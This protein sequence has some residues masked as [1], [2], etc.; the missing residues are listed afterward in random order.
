MS[1]AVPPLLQYAFMAWCLVKYRDNFTFTF[2]FTISQTTILRLWEV[3]LFGILLE[4]F[5]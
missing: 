2:T 4:N 5:K 3:E 1:G